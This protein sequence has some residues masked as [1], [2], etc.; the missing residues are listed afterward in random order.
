MSAKH[1]LRHLAVAYNHFHAVDEHREFAK[2]LEAYEKT[3][4]K[5]EIL[6]KIAAVEEKSELLL[7]KNPAAIA[8]LKERIKAMKERVEAG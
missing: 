2:R 7:G 6:A 4:L 8:R 5:G 1:F 3:R